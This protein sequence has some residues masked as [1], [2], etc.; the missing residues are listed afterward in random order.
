MDDFPIVPPIVVEDTPKL[1]RLATL[2]DARD[3]GDAAM[4]APS[5]LQPG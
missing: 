3:Y 5:A 2:K 4:R 1:R